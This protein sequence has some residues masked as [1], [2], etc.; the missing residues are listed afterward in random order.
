MRPAP[1][2]TAAIYEELSGI[3]ALRAAHH[4]GDPDTDRIFRNLVDRRADRLLDELLRHRE[5]A[6]VREP[7]RSV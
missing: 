4:T 5:A 7:S 2:P 1:R 3:P 6:S